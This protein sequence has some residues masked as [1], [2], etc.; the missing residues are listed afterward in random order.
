MPQVVY[1]TCIALRGRSP[2]IKGYVVIYSAGHVP[3]VVY[4]TC[5][6]LRGR[7]PILKEYISS[8]GRMP[9]VVHATW[10][11]FRGRSSTSNLPFMLPKGMGVGARST[12]AG[13]GNAVA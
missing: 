2:I 1:T 13:M 12:L 6:A 10:K 3:L 9:L 4:A 8:A 11:A 5:K 7:S